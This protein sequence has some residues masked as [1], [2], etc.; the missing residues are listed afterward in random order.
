MGALVYMATNLINGKRYVGVTKYGL[1]KRRAIHIAHVRSGKMTCKMIANAIKKYG[2]EMIRFSVL[3]RHATYEEAVTQEERLI[4]ALSPEYNIRGT[5]KTRWGFS[6][7]AETRRKIAFAKTGQKHSAE[8]IAI[9]SR[10]GTEHRDAWMRN[11]QHLGPL[12]RRRKVQCDGIVFD[13]AAAAARRYGI[14]KS[15]ITEMCRGQ[16]GRK[17]VGVK[18]FSYAVV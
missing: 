7:S 11:F 9:L 1:A 14:S 2:A 13:S 16:R 12:S 4:I 15:A 10:L 8:T 17:S 5:K 6:Q 18:Q 3:S